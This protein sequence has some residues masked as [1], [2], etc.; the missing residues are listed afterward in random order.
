MSEFSVG[1]SLHSLLSIL[2][3]LTGHAASYK[4][5]YARAII[6]STVIR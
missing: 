6:D 5:V 2:D 4:T 3:V 1:D